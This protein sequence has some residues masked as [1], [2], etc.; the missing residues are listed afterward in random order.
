F[1]RIVFAMVLN[2][3]VDPGSKRACNEW[4]RNEA[5][6]PEAGDVDVQHFYRVLDLMEAHTDAILDAV[7]RAAREACPDD[8]LATLL[9]DTTTSYFEREFDEATRGQTLEE[10]EAVW[11]GHGDEPSSP[12]PQVVNPPPL[13]MRGH[14]KDRR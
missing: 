5:W 7:G 2:R 6:L 4:V 14:S 1:E 3:L 12:P 10:W 8:E 9:I 13:R 11:E